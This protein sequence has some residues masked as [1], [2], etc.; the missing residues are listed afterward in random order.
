MVRNLKY[1]ILNFSSNDRTFAR[2][3]P[4]N[5]SNSRFLKLARGAQMLPLVLH[6][7]QLYIWSRKTWFQINSSKSY[8]CC[9]EPSDNTDK[10]RSLKIT[11][12][13]VNRRQHQKK[14]LSICFPISAYSVYFSCQVLRLGS[15]MTFQNKRSGSEIYKHLDTNLHVPKYAVNKLFHFMMT[16]F[17]KAL[18]SKREEIWSYDQQ[19]NLTMLCLS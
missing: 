1:C 6:K 18:K 10:W 3:F 17:E 7:S 11:L 8:T 4:T 19:N 13:V 2:P 12:T 14:S 15:K 16:L 9:V 5:S